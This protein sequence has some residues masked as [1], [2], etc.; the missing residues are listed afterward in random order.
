MSDS[1]GS[2]SQAKTVRKLDMKTKLS[3]LWIFAMFNYL[4]ADIVTLINPEALKLIQSGAVGPLQINQGFLQGAA[5]LM[6]K[7][8][9]VRSPLRKQRA[10][11]TA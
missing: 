8:L 10:L 2:L 11:E 4:Y 3:T 5:I 7:A 6:E 9:A 1:A